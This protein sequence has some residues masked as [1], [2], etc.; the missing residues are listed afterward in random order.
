[1]DTALGRTLE[2][3]ARVAFAALGC[4]DVARIDFRLDA[5]G[6]PC[7]LECNPLPGLA[8]D[9]SV[10]SLIA[11]GAGIDYPAL[12]AAILDPALRRVRRRRPTPA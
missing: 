3:S 5:R 11:R 7:F 8:P 4:R 2:R 12:V 1:V 6:R 9:W 10:L